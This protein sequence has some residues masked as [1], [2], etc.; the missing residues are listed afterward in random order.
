MGRY[1]TAAYE[2][3]FCAG[4]SGGHIPVVLDIAVETLDS[5]TRRDDQG[6]IIRMLCQ[7]TPEYLPADSSPKLAAG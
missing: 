2:K 5:F 6:T 3:I 7:L 1:I 4:K